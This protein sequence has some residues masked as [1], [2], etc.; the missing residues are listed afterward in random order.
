MFAHE[1][2]GTGFMS[3]IMDCSY[4]YFISNYPRVDCCSITQIQITLDGN[5]KNRFVKY[6]DTN[7]LKE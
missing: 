7:H 1:G 2:A 5:T 6:N 4:A 3:S